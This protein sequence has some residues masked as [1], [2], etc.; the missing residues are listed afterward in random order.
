MMIDNIEINASKIKSTE[1]LQ[2]MQDINFELHTVLNSSIF[3]DQ[4]LKMKKHQDTSPYK[5]YS[6][7][8]IYQKI[9]LGYKGI[10]DDSNDIYVYV[11]ELFSLKFMKDLSKMSPRTIFLHKYFFEKNHRAK[12][13]TK[14]ISEYC[15]QIGFNKSQGRYTIHNQIVFAY[16]YAY[17]KIFN[18]WPECITLEKRNWRK[19]WTR[20]I[21]KIDYK[22]PEE[23][24]ANELRL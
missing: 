1:R 4:I 13:E 21:I 19:L 16:E 23:G 3:R 22:W 12:C 20:K 14:V 17:S 6:N 8:E 5:F 15:K 11:T 10:G 2:K 9:M 18:I 24:L 7:G